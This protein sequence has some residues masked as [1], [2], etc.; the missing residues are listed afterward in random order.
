MLLNITTLPTL[1]SVKQSP[2]SASILL[3]NQNK[4]GTSHHNTSTFPQ[5]PV[6]YI[7]IL[8][9]FTML[10]IGCRWTLLTIRAHA[11][12]MSNF[13]TFET[14]QNIDK[15][16]AGFELLPHLNDTLLVCDQVFRTCGNWCEGMSQLFSPV[17]LTW[18]HMKVYFV[19]HQKNRLLIPDVARSECSHLG[20][21]HH[22]S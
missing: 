5:A 13:S 4:I 7:H 19:E 8:T 17:V 14:G 2:W 18:Y 3:L 16:I 22:W 1:V 12:H 6:L 15:Q 10:F 11:G 9:S 21:S 20:A